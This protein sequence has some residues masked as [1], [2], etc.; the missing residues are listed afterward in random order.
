[1]A[2]RL[3][4][5]NAAAAVIKHLEAGQPA[6]VVLT[7]AAGIA[8][9]ART[10]RCEYRGGDRARGSW[11]RGSARAGL[12]DLTS[13]AAVRA[14]L[15]SATRVAFIDPNGGG[16][17]GPLIAKLFEGLGIA[18]QMTETGVLSKT[19]KDVVRA[20]VSGEAT[21]GLDA[22]HRADR[23][24]GCAVC[25]LSRTGGAGGQRVFG[26]CFGLRPSAGCRAALPSIP[27]EPGRY[28]SLPSCR[29]GSGLI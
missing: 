12:P 22:G 1:M 2:V 8:Q 9:V 23:S 26:G 16:T 20:V 13:A 15:V 7:S 17:S 6:G 14:A 27:E 10:G 29:M 5:A 11:R 24:E 4:V 21:L 28:R 25:G 19:G 18:D 3:A